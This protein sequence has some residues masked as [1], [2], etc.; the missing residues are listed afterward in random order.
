MQ[1]VRWLRDLR[2]TDLAEV[3]GKNASLGEM[4]GSLAEAGIRVP[5]GFATTARAYQEF[6]A[7]DG[8][9][10]AHCRSP[11][12][13][14]PGRRPQ[15]G[16]V[17]CRDPRVD[18]E[19]AAAEAVETEIRSFYQ[20]LTKQC[21]GEI[22]F[23][24]RSSAP[25]K[26]CPIRPSPASRRPSSTSAARRSAGSDPQGLRL[27]L[28]RPG[29]LVPGAPRLRARHGSA[30]GRCATMVRSDLGAAGVMFTL[31]TESGFRDVVFITSSWGL[32]ETVV[33]GSVNPDEFYVHKPLLAQGHAAILRRSLGSKLQRM[34]FGG[35]ASAGPLDENRGYAG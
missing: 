28:Q 19:S 1:Y 14:R 29:D 30:F 18:R 12:H 25:P 2:M 4:L 32:G 21:S 13:T 16:E 8:L 11:A 17:R 27:A 23:A 35:K 24:V 26:T 15:P 34:V 3:G 20:E 7:A 9:G 22:S 33:Q 31:D 6:L 10:R 5:E